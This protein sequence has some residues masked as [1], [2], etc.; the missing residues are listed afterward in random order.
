MVHHPDTYTAIDILYNRN[1][2][3]YISS[4]LP[5]KISGP[6]VGGK[7]QA[8]CPW[9]TWLPPRSSYHFQCSHNPLKLHQNCSLF[10]EAAPWPRGK[11]LHSISLMWSA[12]CWKKLQGSSKG[13]WAMG[14]GE[15]AQALQGPRGEVAVPMV[16]GTPRGRN[17]STG[18]RGGLGQIVMGLC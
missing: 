7:G 8:T 16:V 6:H 9:A 15:Q 12:Q 2:R 5:L 10:E 1:T 3:V 17:W 14:D 13:K 18:G 11:P 4:Y